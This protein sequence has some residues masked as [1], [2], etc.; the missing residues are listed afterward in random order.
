MQ[1]TLATKYNPEEIEDKW[2]SF[3]ETENIFHGEPDTNKKPYSIVI[4]PPNITGV[5]HMGHALNNTLQDIL[6]RWKRMQGYNTLWMPGTDHAG[7]ATQNVVERALAKEG[8]NK[9]A[10]GRDKFIEKVWTWREKYGSTIIKQLKKLGSACDWERERF[11]MDEGLSKAVREIFVQLYDKGLIYKGN[12]VINWCPRCRT[13]L[14]D[15]E[16]EHE[17]HEGHLWHIKY[18]FRDEPHLHL[19]VATTRPETMLGDVAVAVNPEDERY[20]EM[21]GEV[22]LLPVLNKEL[23]IYGD[24]FV[25]KEFGTGAVKI[26]PAHDNNDFEMSIRHGLKPVTV[27]ND[28][29]TMN[30]NAGDYAGMDRFECREA[31][32]EELKLKDL[33]VK[34]EPHNHSV[35]HCYRCFTVIEPYLSNQWFIKMKPLAKPA[36]DVVEKSVV[37]FFPSRWSKVYLSWLENVRD[38]CISRQIW[39]GHRIPAWYCE[40]CEGITVSKD[41]PERCSKCDS[42]KLKQEEDVLDTWFSS[43]LWPFSTMGWPDKTKELDYFYPTS[44]LVTDRGIIYFWVARMVMMGMEVMKDIPFDSVYIHGTILDEMGRKMSKSLG[45]GIDPLQMIDKFGADAV[46]VSLILLTSEGQDVKLSENKFEMGRNF[47]NKVWNA[48][49]FALMNI[50]SDDAKPAATD[51]S[52][53]DFSFEDYWILSRL[54]TNIKNATDH[55]EKFKF[56][57]AIKV[58]YDFFWHDFC[59]WYLEIVKPRMYDGGEEDDAETVDKRLK[60]RVVA[61][62]NLVYVLDKTL[63]LLHPFAPFLTEEIWQMLKEKVSNN[64]INCNLD[65]GLDSVSTIFCRKDMDHKSIMNTSW[66]EENKAFAS[67]ETENAMELLQSIIRSI[68]NIRSKMNI[69]QKQAVRVLIST[70]NEND[71]KVL[72]NHKEFI[73]QV[74]NLE[75]L[76]VNKNIIKPENSA[77]EVVGQMQIFVPLSGL[78]DEDIEN[79]RQKKR[80]AELEKFLSIVK[81]KLENEN[82]VGK[83]PANVVEKEREREKELIEQITKVKDSISYVADN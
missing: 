54:N 47:A 55:L 73:G 3:W 42:T 69:L 38:W 44:T 33:I 60:S 20:K 9:E 77:S 81:S 57:E 26:T 49:R 58:I 56:N 19:T 13:A 15:D 39:W 27:L 83:A 71:I 5:L 21:I 52:K 23:K 82:F 4:P 62:N 8:T 70:S 65:S 48:S 25:D 22:L 74:G 79:E 37:N 34:V 66:P 53:D 64:Q 68:R 51:I 61:Q 2:Y 41:D 50:N 11:T 45:N 16:V 40:D 80:L 10:I 31:L 7:I 75:N 17:E 18:P 24:E 6:I 36:I 1:D 72:N 28:D 78:V 35:G 32:V 76:E 14:A 46:R 43:A 63:R 12:Y 67:P 30:T 59:D 29:G